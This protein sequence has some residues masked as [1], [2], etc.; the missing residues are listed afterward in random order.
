[1]GLSFAD[2]GDQ[3]PVFHPT[4]RSGQSD[5]AMRSLPEGVHCQT[6]GF[7][8]LLCGMPR[9]GCKEEVMV[10]DQDEVQNKDRDIR[11][12]SQQPSGY[13]RRKRKE[14]TDANRLAKHGI[15]CMNNQPCQR[16]EK[17]NRCQQIHDDG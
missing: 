14:Y 5:E 3:V 8:V 10:S 7:K 15:G 13:M 9:K 16:A 12:F 2:V 6:C 4:D 11:D 17:K 1:V